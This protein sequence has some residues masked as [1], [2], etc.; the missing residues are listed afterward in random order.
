EAAPDPGPPADSARPAAS[1]RGPPALGEP[2]TEEEESHAPPPPPLPAPPASGS[3]KRAGSSI[4]LT[5][6]ELLELQGATDDGEVN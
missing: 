4:Y 2:E 1:V 3:P 5:D 6:K